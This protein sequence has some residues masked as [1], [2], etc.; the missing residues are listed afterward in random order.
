MTNAE[1]SASWKAFEMFKLATLG[2]ARP[3]FTDPL[4][5]Y[6]DRSVG[7]TC[8]VCG[9][10]AQCVGKDARNVVAVRQM[11]IDHIDEGCP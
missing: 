8:L 1:H 10:V 5:A 11:W 7:V 3:F 9:W 2:I 4:P 6:G